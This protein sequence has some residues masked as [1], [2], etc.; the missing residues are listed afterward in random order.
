MS[1]TDKN[2]IH[3]WVVGGHAGE[4]IMTKFSPISA[5][6]RAL[7]RMNIDFHEAYGHIQNNIWNSLFRMAET[8]KPIQELLEIEDSQLTD[9]KWGR[10]III[11]LE[12]HAGSLI[13]FCSD[14]VAIKAQLDWVTVH[15]CHSLF[16]LI[17][18]ANMI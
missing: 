14:S 4:F 18:T 3:G 17:V 8:A 2:F 11:F 16:L 7:F 13:M 12:K 10:I 15:L 6:F 1:Q 5:L 9:K